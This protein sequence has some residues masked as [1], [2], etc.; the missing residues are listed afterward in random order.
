MRVMNVTKGREPKAVFRPSDVACQE[1]TRLFIGDRFGAG[2]IG[3]CGLCRK[4]S[5][6]EDKGQHQCDTAFH[7]GRSPKIA[8]PIRT[9]VDPS[10]MAIR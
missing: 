5:C 1:G 7:T 8:V 9:I 10:S 2:I 6:H 4:E 3:C